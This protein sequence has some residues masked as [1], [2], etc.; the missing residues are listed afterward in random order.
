MHRF[1]KSFYPGICAT[2]LLFGNSLHLAQAQATA[3]P[4]HWKSSAESA[5]RAQVFAAVPAS[6]RD[7][8]QLQW[9]WSGARGAAVHTCDQ[10]WEVGEIKVQQLARVHVPLRCGTARGSVA[11][12]VQL[13]APVWQTTRALPAQHVLAASDLQTTRTTVQSL[14]QLLEREAL[15]GLQLR[16]DTAAHTVLGWSQLVRPVVL[17]KGD[18][19]EIRASHEGVTVH[20]DGVATRPTRLGERTVV[21][22]VRSQELIHGRLIAPRLLEADAQRQGGVKVVMESN[23]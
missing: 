11:G 16:R 3:T 9:Q 23:D 20:V 6:L 15:L 2:V 12:A 19:L 7:H 22:N 1:L 10:A 5:A 21:R 13:L 4:H 14:D 18:R 17:R 8:V